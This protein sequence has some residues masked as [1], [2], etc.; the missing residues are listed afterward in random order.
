VTIL[1]MPSWW[2]VRRVAAVLVCVSSVLLAAMVWVVMLRR[3][4]GAQT[5]LIEHKIQKEATIEERTRIARELHDTLAQGFVG[6]AFQLEAVATHLDDSAGEA[7]EHLDLALTMVRHSL[8]EARRSVL[9]LRAQSLETS[10][11]AGALV[12][13]TRSLLTDS[14]VRFELS[15]EGRPRRLPAFVENNTL[16]IGQEA[17]TNAIKYSLADHIQIHL[18]YTEESV[19]LRV[20]DFGS[21]FDAAALPQ[22]DGSHFGLR[23]MRER[24]REMNAELVL[25]SQRGRGT[26]VTVTVPF[27]SALPT[28]PA[29]VH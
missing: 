15:T 24:A 9:N 19:T 20:E 13:T 4:V 8:G 16:R 23:G 22:D 14:R 10:D 7:R 26:A 25:D 28:N 29:R 27:I 21:G 12:E 17:I 2:T 11:L 6:I 18:R 3:R 1:E 5:K